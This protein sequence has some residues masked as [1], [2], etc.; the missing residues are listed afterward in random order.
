MQT[1]DKELIEAL[2]NYLDDILENTYNGLLSQIFSEI[3]SAQEHNMQQRDNYYMFKLSQFM[4]QVL[5]HR[6]YEAFKLSK[7]EAGQQK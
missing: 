1:A 5:R 4:I 3:V 6:A 2:R 7:K